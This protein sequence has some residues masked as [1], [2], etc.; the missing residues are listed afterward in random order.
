MLIIFLLI[1]NLGIANNFKDMPITLTQPDGSTIHCLI[2]GDEF[3]QRLHDEDNY[4]II[5]DA[6]D[7]YYYYAK[8]D[9]NKINRTNFKVGS[10]N[11]KNIGVSK[12]IGISKEDYLSIR[13]E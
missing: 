13:E 1:L 6:V 10:I 7:G 4:T 12:N 8:K 9:N 3:Y 5:Q 2:S 11:P